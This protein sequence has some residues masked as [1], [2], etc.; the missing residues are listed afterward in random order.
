[1]TITIEEAQGPR[2]NTIYFVGSFTGWNFEPMAQD[3]THPFIF[4][5]GRELP[6]T[7]DGEFKFGT[8]AGSWDNMYHPTIPQ[9]PYTHSA[10]T[11][12]GSGDYKWVMTEA[13][14]N[15]AYKMSLDI[16]EGAEKFTMT[17]FTPYTMIYLVG[18]ATPNGWDIGNATPMTATDGDPYTFIWAGTLVEGE[19]KFTCDKQSDWGG[20]WFLAYENGLAPNGQEQQMVFSAR[21]DGGNDRKWNITSAGNYTIILNQLTETASIIKN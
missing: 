6:W 13:E 1:L 2:F 17:L 16:T 10:V 9:A 21:G 7:P 20:A 14:C 15:K 18:G 4:K 8:Q 5:Y 11:M 12:D 19:M 3:I